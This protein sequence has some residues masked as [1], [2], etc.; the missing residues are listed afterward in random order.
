MIVQLGVTTVCS[1]ASVIRFRGTP[2]ET[3]RMPVASAANEIFA[4]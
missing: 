4:I 3:G 2:Q 1:H